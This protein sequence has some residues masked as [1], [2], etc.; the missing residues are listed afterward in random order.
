M[1][2]GKDLEARMNDLEIHTAHQDQVITELSDTVSEQWETITKLV[3][4]IERLQERFST[5]E[6]EVQS[7]PPADQPP[8]HY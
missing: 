3:R 5:M 6:Q 4:N 7:A 1:D 2:G 8:P